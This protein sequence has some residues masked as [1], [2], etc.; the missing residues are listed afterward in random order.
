[1]L[2]DSA[3]GN[4]EAALDSSEL[5]PV[6]TELAQSTGEGQ[7][8]FQALMADRSADSYARLGQFYLERG[9]VD[10][11]SR[12]FQ[13]AVSM[14][15][16]LWKAHY[17][18]G[19]ALLQNGD[20]KRAVDELRRVLHHTP[21]DS[22]AHNALGMAFEA[23]RNYNSA[24]EEFKAALTL[25]PQFD[26]AYFNLAHVLGAQ[27]KYSAVSRGSRS[28]RARIQTGAGEGLHR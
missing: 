5:P 4:E 11:A 10:C 25:N 3:C 17:G 8:L 18:L 1:M 20:G 6:C 12:A 14:D 23:M 26:L 27:K 15:D 16:Q 2:V 24:E 9:D 13:S 22:M 7:E 19:L 21:Q 28:S